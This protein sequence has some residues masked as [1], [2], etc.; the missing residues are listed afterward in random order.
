MEKEYYS[1]ND[2]M[3]LDSDSAM[4]QAAV[5]AAAESGAKVVIPRRNKRTGK[6]FW[7]ITKA[8]EL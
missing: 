4:I 5:D 1:P 3:N 2:F 7:N 8:V 6:D